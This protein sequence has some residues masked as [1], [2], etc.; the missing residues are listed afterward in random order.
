[1]GFLALVLC[2][3]KVMLYLF[4]PREEI[5][6]SAHMGGRERRGIRS[7]SPWT[8]EW[9][10][11][12]PTNVYSIWLDMGSAFHLVFLWFLFG[13]MDSGCVYLHVFSEIIWKHARYL[14]FSWWYWH[15]H[16]K[17]V[18]ISIIVILQHV[19]QMDVSICHVARG[20]DELASEKQDH[21]KIALGNRNQTL[22]TRCWQTYL[23]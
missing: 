17:I 6:Y 22:W 8:T 18:V 10:Q 9:Y 7:L 11:S 14:F 13:F 3:G 1:M 5:S 19:N 15:W 20:A 4:N 21:W 23:D 2:L 16:F 12:L